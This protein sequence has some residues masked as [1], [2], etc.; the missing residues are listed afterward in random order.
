VIFQTVAVIL[1]AT[2][3]HALGVVAG[4]EGARD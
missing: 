4:L 3:R 1:A 2:P